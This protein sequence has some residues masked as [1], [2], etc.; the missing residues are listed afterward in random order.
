MSVA[1]DTVVGL[2]VSRNSDATLL[3][4]ALRG[5]AVAFSEIHRRYS[6]R[7]FAFSLARLMSVD[8]AQDATQEVFLRLLAA[9]P[10]QVRS[11]SGWLFGVARH[12][13]IDISRSRQRA[14]PTESEA[15][16]SELGARASG[17]SAEDQALSQAEASDVFL[18]L[19]RMKPRYRTVLVL[20][21]L[22]GQSMSEIA[23]ALSINMGAAYTL[24]SRA[25]DAF[26]KAYAGTHGLPSQCREAVELL[27]RETGSGISKAQSEKLHAHLA[28]CSD[29]GREA[30][31]AKDRPLFAGLLPLLPMSWSTSNGL[32]ARAFTR[33]GGAAPTLNTL[34]PTAPV[35]APWAPV[36]VA[37]A[38]TVAVVLGA[39]AVPA[40]LRSQLNAENDRAAAARASVSP[41]MVSSGQGGYQHGEPDDLRAQVLLQRQRRFGEQA[42]TTGGASQ[43]GG[44]GGGGA[45]THGTV[46]GSPS[47][48]GVTKARQSQGGDDDASGS[49]GSSKT[50]SSADS[51]A[52]SG[53][54][55]EPASGGAA[56]GQGSGGSQGG[57]AGG[58][59]PSTGAGPQ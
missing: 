19:R 6:G 12:V 48:A 57:S 13:C 35:V 30:R 18:A 50:K 51:G 49:S 42:A 47:P 27:Y 31:N 20:R 3:D 59:T 2:R 15:I 8:A 40:G 10:D 46:A 5:D 14:V 41:P 34:A 26:G 37:A 23:E 9:D 25:R 17:I 56:S 54:W 28:Q 52:S 36:A 22:H 39:I 38:V 58:D 21:E 33:L 32:L 44:N 4:S 29:C 53:A 7:V 1:R 24:L 55:K 11:I 43:V 45:Q 16:E